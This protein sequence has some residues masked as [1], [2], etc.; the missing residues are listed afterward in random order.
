[1]KNNIKYAEPLSIPQLYRRGWT[2]YFI[3]KLLGVD[4]ADEGTAAVR[5]VLLLERTWEFRRHLRSLKTKA[6]R[7]E[8]I[9][10]MADALGEV[11]A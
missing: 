9:L 10:S 1:M 2:D 11:A 4:P 7:P 6:P 3:R 5:D 8:R